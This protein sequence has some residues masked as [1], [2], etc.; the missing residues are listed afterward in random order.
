[1][2]DRYGTRR[3][4]KNKQKTQSNICG[5]HDETQC[6]RVLHNYAMAMCVCALEMPHIR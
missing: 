2:R 4:G 3:T 5:S 6:V 1:M